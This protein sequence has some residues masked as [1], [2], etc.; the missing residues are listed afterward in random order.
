MLAPHFQVALNADISKLPFIF[1]NYV[2]SKYIALKSTIERPIFNI[3][4]EW[5]N[6]FAGMCMFKIQTTIFVYNISYLY[7]CIQYMLQCSKGRFSLWFHK[8]PAWSHTQ[9]YL[10]LTTLCSCY[11]HVH[12]LLGFQHS[13]CLWY[14]VLKSK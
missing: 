9:G 2:Y 7:I 6:F 1:S 5:Q 13:E 14:S 3:F 4:V 10:P 8:S 11:Q 12:L